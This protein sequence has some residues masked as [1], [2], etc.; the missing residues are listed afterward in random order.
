MKLNITCGDLATV[1]N[2]VRGIIPARSTI[3][4]L[5]NV[6]LLAES[7]RVIITANSTDM[8]A[9]VSDVCEVETP[10]V[11][12][13]PGQMLL[14]LAK[15]LPK[16]KLMTLALVDGRIAVTCGRSKYDLPT[17]DPADFPTMPEME[18]GASV[19]KM[20]SKAILD[21]LEAT[22]SSV[23]TEA[24][25]YYLNG[26]AAC[27]EGGKLAFVSTDGHRLSRIAQD[28]PDGAQ[29]LPT[30]IIPTAAVAQ[31]ANLCAN[32]EGEATVTISQ[33]RISV[34]LGRVIFRSKLV[35]GTYPDYVRIISQAKKPAFS[36]ESDVLSDAIGRLLAVSS[37]EVPVA[38]FQTNGT[39][40]DVHLSRAGSKMGEGGAETVDAEI[41]S[42]SNF[43][44]NARYIADMVKLWPAKAKLEFQTENPMDPILVTSK[45]MPGMVSVVMP[46][47]G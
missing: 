47:R 6:H 17:L 1:L 7:S 29:Q 15:S 36:I 10:G 20:P 21:A 3:P 23:S 19:F 32:I 35:A 13:V 26:V 30:S 8:Q 27:L 40:V 39:A 34:E 41:I 24:T 45:D 44:A 28:L 16:D 33:S 25:R 14:S 42:K 37:A 11:T 12:T 18:D 9:S 43:A 22:R 2:Q 31:I 38:V 4:I 5:N 46:C